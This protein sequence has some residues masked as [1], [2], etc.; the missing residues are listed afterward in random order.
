MWYIAKALQLIGLV[1]VLW[2]LFIGISQDDLRLEL[3]IAIIGAV[4]FVAGRL[5][6]SK[7]PKG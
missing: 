2:G 5:L 6:E 4:I 1:Q 3:K 7:S